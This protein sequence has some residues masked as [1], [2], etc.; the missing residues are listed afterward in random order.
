MSEQQEEKQ[1]ELKLLIL[2][3][4][5]PCCSSNQVKYYE[6]ITN[7]TFGFHCFNCGWKS[8]YNL[9]ELKQASANWFPIQK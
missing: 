6:Y 3:G 9:T 2:M 7:R 5:C 8:K 4:T 1:K